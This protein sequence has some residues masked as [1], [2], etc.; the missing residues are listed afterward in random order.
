ME[1][2]LGHLDISKKYEK[3]NIYTLTK[4]ATK[5]DPI[6]VIDITTYILIGL[7]WLIFWLKET[8]VEAINFL[9]DASARDIDTAMKLGAGYPMGPLELADYVGLDT[10]H[11]IMNGWYEKY[12]ENPLFK[13]NKAVKK[14]LDEGK[15]GIKTGEGFYPYKK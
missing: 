4:P 14:L 7:L 13:P 8:S 1:N 15:A 11:H 5:K 10:C 3:V 12:P 9:G 6:K 2:P